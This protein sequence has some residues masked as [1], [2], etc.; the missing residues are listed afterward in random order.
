MIDQLIL[1]LLINTSHKIM[2]QSLSDAFKDPP[3]T[4]VHKEEVVLAKDPKNRADATR[5]THTHPSP[6]PPPPPPPPLSRGDFRPICQ[7]TSRR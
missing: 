5:E 4:V 7:V 2:R 3:A 1:S 6:P